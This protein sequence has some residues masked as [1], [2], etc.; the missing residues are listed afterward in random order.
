MT[1]ILFSF[2]H[3]LHP[4]HK[5]YA[6]AHSYTHGE[7]LNCMFVH[8]FFSDA[9]LKNILPSSRQSVYV[10]LWK[11]ALNDAPTWCISLCLL[12]FLYFTVPFQ[13]F[14]SFLAVPFQTFAS[15]VL[16]LS[17]KLVIIK[18]WRGVCVTNLGGDIIVVACDDGGSTSSFPFS[19]ISTRILVLSL[20]IYF[21]FPFLNVCFW[22]CGLFCLLITGKLEI[23]LYSWIEGSLTKFLLSSFR[24]AYFIIE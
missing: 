16:E 18:L 8:W 5:T 15:F 20:S 6:R 19:S 12:V 7:V 17:G 13:K 21:L 23:S 24:F 3:V 1:C 22:V 14:I 10:Y 9:T 11:A 2:L 4:P